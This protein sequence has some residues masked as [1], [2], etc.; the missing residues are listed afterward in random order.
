MRTMLLFGGSF[1]PVHNGHIQTLL[2]VQSQFNFDEVLLLPCKSPVLKPISVATPLQR[3]TMLQL[4]IKPYPFLK[5]DSREIHR[6]TPSY[7][8]DTLIS[9]RD[10]TTK[11]LSITLLLGQDSL[12][13]LPQWHRWEELIKLSH[14]L[15]ISRPGTKQ[16][17]YPQAIKTLLINHETHNLNDLQQFS[18][19][20]IIRFNAGLHD[21]ASS[22]L[23]LQLQLGNN[24]SN[25]LPPGVYQWIKDR[26]LY[27]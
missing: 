20:K 25:Y 26:A 12:A 18:H 5:I 2:T 7:M 9:I 24:I 10:E 6:T 19:G 13:S 8:V 23:R 4:A 3:V 22:D 14:F 1:D 17:E 27:Q 21:I 11:P 15:V 16:E